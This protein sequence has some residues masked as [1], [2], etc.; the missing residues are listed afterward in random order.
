M[1]DAF[2]GKVLVK[3]AALLLGLGCLLSA[4]AGGFEDG[5]DSI[6]NLNPFSTKEKILPGERTALESGQTLIDGE[7][8]TGSAA[9][10]AV[11]G[12]DWLQPGGD[13]AN[14]A[15]H[16]A[17]ASPPVLSF[18]ANLG[19][20]DK[21][22]RIAARP[23]ATGSLVFVYKPDGT[24]TALSRGGGQA[25]QRSLRP[26]GERQS[27]PGGG[28]TTDGQL[29]YVATGYRRFAAL[30]AANG[31]EMWL[32]DLRQPA[33][34]APTVFGDAVYFV[35]QRNEVVALSTADG[36]VLWR[37]QGIPQAAGLLSAANPAIADG[38][39]VV[40]YS[41]GEIIAFDAKTG[42][43]EWL[44]ALST[45]NRIMA[46]SGLADISGSPVIADGIVYATGVSGRTIAIKLA[47]GERLW[48]QD[49]G[50]SF[51]P[52][53]SG[54][55][56]FMVDINNGMTALDRQTG[57]PLWRT[58][59]PRAKKSQD[60]L[61]WVGPVLAGN[62]LYAF[63]AK[64]DLAQVDPTTGRLGA[65]SAPGHGAGVQP[66][67]SNGQMILISTTNSVVGFR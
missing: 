65:V 8:R 52:I 5:L 55:A 16:R 21:A 35:T 14:N 60:R 51:T 39:V 24:V 64:G 13:A 3:R 67:I 30:N 22:V 26:D 57:E 33:R 38:K 56:L 44:D 42:A 49:V 61:A 50:S 6:G 18:R 48:E 36:S 20:G 17:F 62:A 11:S 63:S 45:G 25:W 66:I 19:G 43:I 58:A 47:S 41:S 46:I 9:I 34:G 37:N 59:L 40:P 15:G 53:L 27:T 2:T 29:V 54:N 23:V 7:I 1:T 10:G 31:K 12:G 28:V 32:T 4:C